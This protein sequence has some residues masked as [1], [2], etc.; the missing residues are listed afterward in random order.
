WSEGRLHGT[1]VHPV[2]AW[3]EVEIEGGGLRGVRV[4]LLAAQLLA[5][6]KYEH[7]PGALHRIGGKFQASG[8]QAT[9]RVG[10]LDPRL[11]V[12]PA[13]GRSAIVAPFGCVPALAQADEEAVMRL[14]WDVVE[15]DR[16]I[17]VNGRDTPVRQE[18]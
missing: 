16:R 3:W 2:L 17:F 12:G 6:E 4:D 1:Y 18:H 7:S 9:S 8:H 13:P 5:V 15:R 11:A 14:R 10:Q